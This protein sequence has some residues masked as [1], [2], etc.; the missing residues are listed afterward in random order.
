M[1]WL[2]I[3]GKSAY[4]LSHLAYMQLGRLLGKLTS[5]AKN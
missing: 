2:D 5:L 3:F 1:F 4:S